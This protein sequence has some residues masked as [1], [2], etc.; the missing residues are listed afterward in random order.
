MI[1]RTLSTMVSR[2]TMS[3]KT[4]I[5]IYLIVISL[6]LIGGIYFLFQ[7]FQGDKDKIEGIDFNREDTKEES[8]NSEENTQ[9]MEIDRT[10]ITAQILREGTGQVAKNGDKITAHYTGYLED[11]TKFDSSLDRGQPFS[12]DLG[13]G[14]VIQ[15]WD[16]GINGMKVGE[17]RRL[18]IPP[19]F[20]YGESGASGV[21]PPNALLIFEVELLGINQ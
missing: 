4:K 7:L 5:V 6:V 18:I 10:K 3:N 20:G 9:A 14:Q 1:V 11:G 17:V 15:G 16:L 21:I 19:Q 2:F 13:A 12:F 8:N